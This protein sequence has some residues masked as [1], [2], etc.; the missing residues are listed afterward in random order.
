[1]ENNEE[2]Q[3]KTSYQK[4][5]ELLNAVA[6][7]A[8][9]YE[10]DDKANE[11]LNAVAKEAE[12]YKPNNEFLGDLMSESENKYKK[13]VF[14]AQIGDKNSFQFGVL[15]EQN[16]SRDP[17]KYADNGRINFGYKDGVDSKPV[18]MAD[19]WLLNGRMHEKQEQQSHAE[20]ENASLIPD[21]AEIE[22]FS[23]AWKKFMGCTTTIKDGEKPI[24]V[25]HARG[26]NAQAVIDDLYLKFTLVAGL[27]PEK[28]AQKA[29]N[30]QD[31]GRTM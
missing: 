20:T 9:W 24:T 25:N 23:S 13:H 5:T 21:T 3:V 12:W 27:T 16:E 1:M 28:D 31:N 7:K 8:E 18:H 19:I 10:S 17:Q 2:K 15:G 26:E 30:Q 11:L 29:A 22:V 6:E 14:F 4:V